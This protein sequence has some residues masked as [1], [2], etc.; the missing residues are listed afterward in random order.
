MKRIWIAIVKL[1]GWKF[2]LPAADRQAE[3]DRCVIIM[4]PHTSAYDYFVGAACVAIL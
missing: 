2:D 1:F 3:M 4:V